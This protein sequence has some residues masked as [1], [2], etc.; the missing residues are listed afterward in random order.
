MPGAPREAA[1]VALSSQGGQPAIAIGVASSQRAPL[2]ASLK[3]LELPAGWE[4]SGDTVSIKRVGP[5]MERAGYIPLAKCG[6]VD[7]LEEAVV[8]G[9]IG[10]RA[11]LQAKRCMTVPTACQRRD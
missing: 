8:A 9:R 3:L 10:E 11:M 7:G 4:A 6:A 1:S 5:G 2:S